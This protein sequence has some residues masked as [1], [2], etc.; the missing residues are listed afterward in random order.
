MS[1]KS[2]HT[3]KTTVVNETRESAIKEKVPKQWK[4]DATKGQDADES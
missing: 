4:I 1:C 2:D 3:E